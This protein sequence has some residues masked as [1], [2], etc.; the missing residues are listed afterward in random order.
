MNLGTNLFI[1]YLIYFLSTYIT[2]FISKNKRKEHQSKQSKLDKLRMIAIKTDEE[3]KQFIDLKYPRT[4]PFKWTF[5]NISLFILKL[6]VMV[7]AFILTRYLWKSYIKFQLPLWSV[8]IIMV[9][10]PIG[11]NKILKK[12]NLHQDDLSVFFGGN[13]K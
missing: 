2:L 10:L 9:I 7:F 11:I 3:Q 5:K 4:E 6:A 13:K 8:M 12:Y 1:A